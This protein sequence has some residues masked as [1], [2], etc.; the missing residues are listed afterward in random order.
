HKGLAAMYVS[1]PRFTKY[2]E[3]GTG[4][5]DAAET[6]KAIIDYYA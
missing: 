6:L 4:E 1:D 5:K 2:Y 3:E